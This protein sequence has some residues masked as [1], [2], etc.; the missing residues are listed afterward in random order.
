MNQKAN[1]LDPDLTTQIFRYFSGS[2][3]TLAPWITPI[4]HGAIDNSI[5]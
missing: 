3:S 2:G 1:S 4:F 5:S